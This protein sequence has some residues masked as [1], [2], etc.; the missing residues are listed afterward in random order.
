MVDDRVRRAMEKWPNV[1]AAFGWLSLDRRGTWM[2]EGR[3]VKHPRTVAFLCRNYL[4]DNSGGWYVQNGP[5]RAYVT[6]AYTPLVV[7][8]RPGAQAGHAGSLVNHT[9]HIV[10]TIEAAAIDEEGSL[11]V[12]TEHG[13]S[14]ID[15]RDL[16]LFVDA[17]RNEDGGVLSDDSLHQAL[18]SAT[19]GE[20][21]RLVLCY[22]ERLIGVEAVRQEDMP[23]RF[24]FVKTPAPPS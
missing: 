24:G 17:L 18:V 23:T 21:S 14:L 6:L 22:G 5:Q 3:A 2:L 13:P 20:T 16:G 9:G 4:R 12:Q 15:D 7:Q 11:V 1:P 19:T 8:L 10:R